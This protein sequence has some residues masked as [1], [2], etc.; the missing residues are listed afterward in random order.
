MAIIEGHWLEL[1]QSITIFV[2]KFNLM[3]ALS[4]HYLIQKNFVFV[5]A[6]KAL[7]VDKIPLRRRLFFCYEKLSRIY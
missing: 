6:S 2:C 4:W 1:N 7:S 5:F 3:W